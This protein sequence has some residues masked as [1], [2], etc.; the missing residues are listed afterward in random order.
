MAEKQEKVH[1]YMS[2]KSITELA[3]EL[4]AE[5]QI[6]PS[7]TSSILEKVR[8]LGDFYFI[9]PN[10]TL[11]EDDWV[12][13]GVASTDN[14]DLQNDTIDA[15]EVFGDHLAE[16]VN[17][18]KIFYEH[19]YRFAKDASPTNRIDEPIGYPYMVE[20]YDNKL[21]IWAVLDKEHPLAQKVWN[22]LSNADERFRNKWG[23]SIGGLLVGSRRSI[24]NSLYGRIQQLPKMRLYEISVTPQPVNPYTWAQV[25]KS[26]I[27]EES[28]DDTAKSG[29]EQPIDKETV[30]VDPK[31]GT[32][33]E[34]LQNK[35]DFGGDGAAGSPPAERRDGEDIVEIDVKKA[36]DEEETKKEVTDKEDA[37]AEEKE[38]APEKEDAETEE[39]KD[40]LAEALENAA[41]EEDASAEAPAEGSQEGAAP[42]EEQKTVEDINEEKSEDKT[43]TEATPEAEKE[44][45]EEQAPGEQETD[46][47]EGK[48]D[49]VLVD[50]LG[51]GGEEE[52]AGESGGDASIEL[53]LD[54]VSS[55]RDAL[56][57]LATRVNKLLEY[58]AQ[59]QADETLDT[60][61]EPAPNEEGP[62]VSEEILAKSLKAQEQILD[63]LSFLREDLEVQKSLLAT[64]TEKI[65]EE[66]VLA[67][68]L[69]A[70]KQESVAE[71]ALKAREN[72][73]PNA[74][75]VTKSVATQEITVEEEPTE[76]DV[77][78]KALSD[79]ISEFLEDSQA[80][81]KFDKILKDPELLDVAK[82]LVAAQIEL[83]SE[84]QDKKIRQSTYR[85]KSAE[86]LEIAKSVLGLNRKEF[87]VLVNKG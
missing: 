85:A 86:I 62:H 24:P 17:V 50:L 1:F 11:K 42:E 22:S 65:E 69:R 30:D 87:T 75:S 79:S 10:I 68:S 5:A 44:S 36:L 77:V 4:P 2:M 3:T 70:K 81:S 34:K 46:S 32:T 84:L 66:S 76:S 29:L 80:Q 31:K 59:E 19:G 60:S 6:T 53:V 33:E 55:L 82:S 28:M 71:E 51:E 52:K 7:T 47:G 16:F 54:E 45:T 83:K 21:W 27:S 8:P 37:P 35:L 64:L 9:N 39:A 15:K 73:N 48:D 23:F 38:A 74:D 12:I 56:E 14:I 58:E 13:F 72:F 63:E 40:S 43:E 49:N 78:V 18:G 57:E 67:K 41:S 20:I 25:V 26:L 61:E